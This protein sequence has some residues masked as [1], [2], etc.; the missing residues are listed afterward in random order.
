MSAV[1]VSSRASVCVR[2]CL[3]V[4][5]SLKAPV[6][7]RTFIIVIFYK[8]AASPFLFQMFYV[9]IYIVSFP[10]R[11]RA[12]AYLLSHGHDEEGNVQIS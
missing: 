11:K 12:R 7:Y 9:F 6:L 10:I 5:V 8:S 3:C 2:A 4:S 1:D